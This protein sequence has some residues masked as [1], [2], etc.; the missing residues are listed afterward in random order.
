MSPNLL[1]QLKQRLQQHDDLSLTRN[2][3]LL[4]AE[5]VL[6]FTS[7]HY[8]AITP[9]EITLPKSFAA[10]GSPVTYYTATHQALEKRIRDWLNYPRAILFTSGYLA[11]LSAITAIMGPDDFVAIDKQCHASVFDGVQLSKAN[12]QRYADDDHERLENIL[13]KN[14]SGLRFIIT[15][16]VFSMQGHLADLNYLIQTAKKYNATLI[17]DDVHG[18]GILGPKGQG[19]VAHWNLTHETPLVI[20]SFTKGLGSLGA[21]I[22]GNEIMIE[23]ILQFA[24]PYMFSTT[25]PSHLASANINAIN[26]AENA[27]DTRAHLQQLIQYF[28]KKARELNLNILPSSTPIQAIVFK[29]IEQ[30]MKTSEKLFAKN[31]WV[32]AIRPPTVPKD[33]PRLRI[34]LT[35]AHQ[36]ADIDNLLMELT[37]NA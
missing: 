13:Q 35:G 37:S 20:G 29:D 18:T 33:S 17:I 26:A 24:R 5:N 12:W 19:A 21:F 23:A 25:L 27:D 11:L 36:C 4:N 14:K 7:N 1:L 32:S 9:S 3:R 30:L 16:S 15:S 31:I 2:R 8:L 28:Q 10:S 6:D 34:T 22:A